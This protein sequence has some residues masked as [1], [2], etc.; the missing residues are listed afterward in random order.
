MSRTYRCRH[1]PSARGWDGVRISRITDGARGNHRARAQKDVTAQVEAE[2]GPR[3][4]ARVLVHVAGRTHRVFIPGVRRYR[5]LGVLLGKPY[6]WWETVP[7]DRHEDR[8]GVWM[9]TWESWAWNEEVERRMR[10]ITIPV[11]SWHP[12]QRR[13]SARSRKKYERVQSNRRGRRATNIL[14]RSRSV[15]DDA[16]R[17]FPGPR[18]YFD[19]RSVY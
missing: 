19:W 8:P 4:A 10:D 3:P 16:D 5:K 13:P 1:L 9:Q 2:F 6:G 18:D 7:L 11:S 14:L 17:F 12:L 15:D